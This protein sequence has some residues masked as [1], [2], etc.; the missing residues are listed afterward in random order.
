[1]II[2]AFEGVFVLNKKNEIDAI[3]QILLEQNA[4]IYGIYGHLKFIFYRLHLYDIAEDD[5]NYLMLITP[6]TLF[7]IWLHWSKTV[8][9]LFDLPVEYLIRFFGGRW[10]NIQT[11]RNLQNNNLRPSINPIQTILTASVSSREFPIQE[12]PK[13]FST[14]EQ[15][16]QKSNTVS[17]RE[18]RT[19]SDE[20]EASS[21]VS[22]PKVNRELNNLKDH[23]REGK[24]SKYYVK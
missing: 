11:R 16:I 9:F 18:E 1:M 6:I 17:N 21:S 10:E 14:N 7:F 2:V 13:K 3:K 4:L 19:E 5:F 23:L 20:V 24:T 22:D 12:E 8:Q 15:L